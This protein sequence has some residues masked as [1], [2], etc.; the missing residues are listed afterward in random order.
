[1]LN[2]HCVLQLLFRE[3]NQDPIWAWQHWR[4]HSCFVFLLFG[5]FCWLFFRSSSVTH[6]NANRP[7][8]ASSARFDSPSS[9]SYYSVRQLL[10]SLAAAA[11]HA[12]SIPLPRLGSLLNGR[13]CSFSKLLSA[14]F[15]FF[16][17]AAKL[18]FFFLNRVFD[19]PSA[20][21][22]H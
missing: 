19:S 3:I 17:I 11:K 20:A 22:G 7:K 5:F 21:R 2:T 4:G 18:W 6:T 10:T 12:L 13:N 14:V 9:S 15:F 8:I 1:M 16:P